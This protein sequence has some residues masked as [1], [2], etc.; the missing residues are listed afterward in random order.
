M[1]ESAIAD[2][3]V[4]DKEISIEFKDQE[5]AFDTLEDFQGRFQ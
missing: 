2:A 5:K 1:L 3:R 4:R